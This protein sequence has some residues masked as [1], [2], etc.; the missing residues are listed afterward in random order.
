MNFSLCANIAGFAK[1]VTVPFGHST[2][3]RYWGEYEQIIHQHFMIT[4][5]HAKIITKVA[6]LRRF[7]K[8]LLIWQAEL[9]QS[10]ACIIYHFRNGSSK[11]WC[12]SVYM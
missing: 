8:S 1:T 5:P 7:S 4:Q 3:T 10:V 12:C 11:L 2:F 9:L 6:D